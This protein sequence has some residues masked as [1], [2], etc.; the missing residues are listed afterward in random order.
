MADPEQWAIGLDVG[1]TKI[2]GALV[3]L[4]AGSLSARRTLPT[5]PERGGQAV[6]D[7][8]LGLARVLMAAA[9]DMRIS[10]TGIGVSVCELV[11]LAGNVTSG[12][13]VAWD[14]LP[15]QAEFG[16]LARA[17]VESD[18]RAH[19]LAEASL[20]AGRGRDLV[21]FAT[22]GTG[23]SSCLVQGG[24]PYAGARGYALVL[25]TSA[26]HLP[27]PVCGNREWPALEEFASGPAL[28]MRYNA[29]GGRQATRAEEVLAAAEAGDANGTAVVGSAGEALGAALGW[30]ANVLDPDV[31]I[32]GGGLGSAGG[33]YW[34]SLVRST[35]EHIWA[36]AGRRQ[37]NLQ[38]SLGPHP[39]L[40]CAPLNVA[41][42]VGTAAAGKG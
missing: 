17:V 35:R 18:V 34:D 40:V 9:D 36:E 7:D 24:R 23:I 41:R 21:V 14:G 6:L 30:M 32:V 27:C 20:G 31:I 26:L 8:A 1:G 19:A 29:A 25:A 5:R 42:R 3:G 22:V 37:P 11:D 16:R 28:V 39:A 15:V 4:P 2:A 38:A 33:L 12:Q 10:V 13:A